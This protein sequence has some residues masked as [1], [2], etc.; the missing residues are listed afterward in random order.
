MGT[1]MIID[2]HSWGQVGLWSPAG[3]NESP[4][5]RPLAGANNAPAGF[6]VARGRR[7]D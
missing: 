7:R 3:L 2:P 1:L 5:T 6:S 4:A